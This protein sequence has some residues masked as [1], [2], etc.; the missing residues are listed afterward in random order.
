MKRHPLERWTPA[1]LIGAGASLAMWSGGHPWNQLAGSEVGH[2]LGWRIAHVWHFMG[3]LLLLFGL[4]GLF[5]QRQDVFRS[6][7]GT[8]ALVVAMVGS[9]LFTAGGVFTAFI[10]PV[11]SRHAPEMVAAEG[12]FFSSLDLL[13]LVTTVTFATGLVLLGTTLRQAGVISRANLAVLT[14][15][16]LLLL[17][18]PP[19]IGP[20]PW[21]LFAL[22]G[23]VTG[24]GVAGIGVSLLRA[25]GATEPAVI[26]EVARPVAT[27][28]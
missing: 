23:V 25:S 28:G 11:L 27:A 7:L 20:A 1:V 3:G 12:P 21:F 19:P 24:I 5:A 16:S 18:A 6:R 2:S 22:S 17:A 13:L 9:A 4:L 8:T 14:V 15:G 10:W 26:S